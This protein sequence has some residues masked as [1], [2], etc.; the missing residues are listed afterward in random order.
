[1]CYWRSI[2]NQKE[3]N[4]VDI[5]CFDKKIYVPLTLHRRVLYWYHFDLNHTSESRL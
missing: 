4:D 5:L 1:M 3:L 2:Y